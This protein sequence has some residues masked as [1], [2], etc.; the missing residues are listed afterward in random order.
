MIPKYRYKPWTYFAAT[1]IATYALWFAGAYLSF[2]DE[3]NGLYMLFM[4]FGLLIPFILSFFMIFT[5]KNSGLKRDFINRLIN[6]RLIK[7]KMFPV[8]FLVMPL[9]VLI[10]IFISLPFGG[11]VSQFQL[12]DGF[13]FS[14][15][16]VPTLVF[17]MLAACF[18]ELGWRGYAF[19]S[20]QSRH[21]YFMA[22]IIFSIL[23]SL[24]HFPLIFVNHFYQY[25]IYHE[26]IW[27]AVN[28]FVGIIPMGV[29][30]SWICI[31][32]GK[33][34]PA[35][36]LFHFIVNICQE[37][38]TVTQTTKCIET[39]VI[40]LVVAII[41]VLDK[42]MFFSKVSPASETQNLVS[43]TQNLAHEAN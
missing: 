41:I 27:Y 21:T 37:A 35:A 30:V 9:T 40:T 31:K 42:D 25:E 4:F 16:S 36:I 18:E 43:E 28:F 8:F 11:S 17:L 2:Q 24:W 22:S 39:L 20:L 10:S 26:N 7:P 14:T 6:L 33:S 13:S 19:D 32:N 29:F 1:F 5:S 23:W 15:G 12:A 3:K 34:I 38:L